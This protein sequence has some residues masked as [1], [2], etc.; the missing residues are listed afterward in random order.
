MIIDSFGYRGNF[1]FTPP[2][3]YKDASEKLI[4][5]S[6]P[7][8]H[9]EILD[10][11]IERMI[12]EF[13]A[14]MTDLDSTSPY[15]K[16]T[17]LTPIENNIY[18]SIQF[19]N[20]YLYSNNNKDKI[21]FGCDLFCL[22]KHEKKI[23]FSQIGWPL[24]VLHQNNKN[25]PISSDYSKKP[26]DLDQGVYLPC[27]L[28]G[29]DS[30]INIKIQNIDLTKKNA[31]LLLKSNETPDGLLTLYPSPLEKIAESFVSLNPNQGFW[32]GSIKF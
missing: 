12:S 22:F 31:L 10:E 9:P 5:I 7:Y 26:N 4:I 24:T 11:A 15:A 18:T 19:L 32:L 27:H 16:L 1:V 21:N 3:V 20:D 25:I 13:S 28:V 17:C 8:G 2:Q 23:I 30:S 14:Q 29:L 6:T